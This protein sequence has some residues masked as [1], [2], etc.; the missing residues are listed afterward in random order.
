A[1]HPPSRPV[2]CCMHTMN[3]LRKSRNLALPAC[4]SRVPGYNCRTTGLVQLIQQT[5]VCHLYPP[6]IPLELGVDLMS[7]QNMV[8]ANRTNNNSMCHLYKHWANSIPTLSC[9]RR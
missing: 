2:R 6:R 9:S 8:Q 5:V 7:Y 1:C 3:L 4:S